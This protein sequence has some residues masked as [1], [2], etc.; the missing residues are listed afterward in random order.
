[1][2][3]RQ[4]AEAVIAAR[5]KIVH[6]AVSMVEMALRELSEKGVVHLDEERKASMV[7]NLLV[8]LCS[9]SQATAVVNNGTSTA[10]R[11]GCPGAQTLPVTDSSQVVAGTR[12]VGGRRPS[13]RQWPDRVHPAAGGGKAEVAAS[14]QGTVRGCAARS[15]LKLSPPPMSPPADD[16][17]DV[18]TLRPKR[19]GEQLKRGPWS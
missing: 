12:K 6:G 13:Q 9:E 14:G 3:R 17:G 8:V 11:N 2:L 18:I 5:Q 16:F 19:T 4:Q 7:S 1:M 15:W 10:E